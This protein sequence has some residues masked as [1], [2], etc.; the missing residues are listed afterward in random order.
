MK[1]LSNAEQK[2]VGGGDT[3]QDLIDEAAELARQILEDLRRSMP[4]PFPNRNN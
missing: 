1:E 2:I 4:N 3:L